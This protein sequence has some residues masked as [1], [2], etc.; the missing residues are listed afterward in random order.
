MDFA[1]PAN[2]FLR[3]GVVWGGGAAPAS[4]DERV[5][6]ERLIKGEGPAWP[7]GYPGT[8]GPFFILTCFEI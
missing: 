3:T 8:W 6:P 1:R 4:K 2:F 7:Q 5:H